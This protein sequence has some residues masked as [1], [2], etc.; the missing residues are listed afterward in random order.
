MKKKL[1]KLE[2]ETLRKL[3]ILAAIGGVSLMEYLKKTL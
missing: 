1:I 2:D 3:N